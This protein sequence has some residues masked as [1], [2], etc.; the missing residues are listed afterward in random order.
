MRM[1]DGPARQERGCDNA[2][3]ALP[4]IGACFYEERHSANS[5]SERLLVLLQDQ[6]HFRIERFRSY[7]P[8]MNLNL[9][10]QAQKSPIIRK[11]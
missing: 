2:A 6:K 4:S 9:A 8:T 7:N 3:M 11:A 1:G 5:S 10:G